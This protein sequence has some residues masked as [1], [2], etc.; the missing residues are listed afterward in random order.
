[1]QLIATN[2]AFSELSRITSPK[3]L[4]CLPFLAPSARPQPGQ[5]GQVASCHLLP[6]LSG[7]RRGPGPTPLS[8]ILEIEALGKGELG[9]WALGPSPAAPGPPWARPPRLRS[10]RERGYGA[11]KVTRRK[12]GSLGG[13]VLDGPVAISY[14][15]L[16]VVSDDRGEDIDLKQDG[17]PGAFSQHVA[18]IKR[19]LHAHC[20]RGA[21]SELASVPCRFGGT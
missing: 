5:H 1:M 17:S 10:E 19:S 15:Q 8:P 6:F 20:H 2:E 4:L 13:L 16:V 21:S 12:L 11:K 18:K 9:C 14:G 3:P 7:R